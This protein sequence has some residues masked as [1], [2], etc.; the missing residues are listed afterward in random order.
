[1][2]Q[3]SISS[4]WRPRPTTSPSFR[5]TI[6][7]ASWMVLTRWAMMSVAASVSSPAS[8]WRSAASVL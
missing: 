6:W 1:M 4:S 5:T 8:A 2:G 3:L 7:S